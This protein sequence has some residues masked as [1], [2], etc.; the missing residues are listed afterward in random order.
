MVVRLGES[1]LKMDNVSL[2]IENSVYKHAVRVRGCF[3]GESDILMIF[4]HEVMK[5]EKCKIMIHGA[6]E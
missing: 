5:R 6:K 3:Q 4:F 2:V 1:S